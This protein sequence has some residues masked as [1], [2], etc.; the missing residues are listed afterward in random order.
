VGDGSLQVLI[1]AVIGKVGPGT[2]M[3]WLAELIRSYIYMSFSPPKMRQ[4]LT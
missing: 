4:K 3:V 2:D 1:N